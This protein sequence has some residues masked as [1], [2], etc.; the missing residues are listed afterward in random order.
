MSDHREFLRIPQT[1]PIIDAMPDSQPFSSSDR[2]SIGS[3]PGGGRRH[4]PE[5]LAE[6]I[7]RQIVHDIVVSDRAP[8]T[9]LPPESVMLEEYRVGRNSLREALRILEVHG[10]ISIKPGPGGGPIV[11]SAQSGEFGRM[12]TLFLHMKR[13]TL[14]ELMEARFA[15]EPMMA[16]LA[17]ERQDANAL[18]SLRTAA[19][20]ASDVP[21]D[22]NVAWFEASTAF[23][24][25]VAGISGNGVLDLVGRSLKDIYY[26]RSRGTVA[27]N[28]AQRDAVRHAHAEIT[29]AI[30]GGHGAAAEQLMRE[31]MEEFLENIKRQNP[32]MLDEIV[33][34]Y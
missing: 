12:V 15:L 19:E 7:A 25:C 28:V 13:S 32:G 31:H 9:M 33:G 10:L 20:L 27:T 4:R 30:M 21:L 11:A 8:G 24:D 14:G 3:S 34:W 2:S 26:A 23:H 17:A 22:D 1:T 5:K 18:E 29:G 16:R 6:T